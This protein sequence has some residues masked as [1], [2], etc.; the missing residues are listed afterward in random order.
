MT[1]LIDDALAT[2]FLTLPVR[3]G[4]IDDSGGVEIRENLS[5]VDVSADDIAVVPLP[6]ATLL[7]RTHVIDR[8]IAVVYDGAGLIA[9][10]TRVRPD[11]I[12]A[13]TI[14]LD[15]ID[16]AG[17]ALARALLRP[18]FGIE[19]TALV[20]DVP[21]ADAEVVVTERGG[22]IDPMDGGFREDLARSWFIMTGKAF[23]SHVTVVGVAA[24][25]RGP[26]AD[27]GRLGAFQATGWE[28]RRDVR[29]AIREATGVDAEVL[30]ELTTRMRFSLAPEDQDPARMLVERGAWGTGYGRSLPAWRDQ[31][32]QLDEAGDSDSE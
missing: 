22:D 27:L 18:Y 28:H 11:E 20:R 30:A 17:E 12:A 7:T 13:T 29:R 31:L 3:E 4:W 19:A 2:A 6:V 24:L 14:W 26:D 23:V 16:A 10:R 15:R 25:A 32:G 21:P 1:I 8:S 9:M 5:A